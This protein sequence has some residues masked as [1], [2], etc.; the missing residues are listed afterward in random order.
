MAYEVIDNFLNK[1]DFAELEEIMM[2][3]NIPWYYEPSKVLPDDSKLEKHSGDLSYN[4]QFIH[5]FYN[6]GFPTSDFLS[7]LN[8]LISKIDPFALL[9][10][11]ANLTTKTNK[12]IEYGYHTDYQNAK[13]F[14]SAVFYINT[15]DGLTK[16]ENGEDICSVANRLVIFDAN[17]SH[18][19]TSH[20]DEKTRVLINLNFYEK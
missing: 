6:N 5:M 9:R 15:N 14:K 4:F 10:I 7:I 3:K 17:M 11:K 12:I 8:P 13:N 1:K 19:G 2:G 20:T 16:F 18:T